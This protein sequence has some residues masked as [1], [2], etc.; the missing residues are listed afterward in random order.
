M[1]SSLRDD[2]STLAPR[3]PEHEVKYPFLTLL[4]SGKHT[5][6]VHTKSA[7]NHRI[8]VTVES[9]I[10]LGDVL[11]KFAREL[12]PKSAIPPGAKTV[13]YP[14]LMEEFVGP[15]PRLAYTACATRRREHEVYRSEH[16]WEIPSP[17]R[18]N[19]TRAYN[20]S[21]LN[22]SLHKIL[23]ARSGDA[24]FTDELRRALAFD[25]MRIAFEHVMSRVVM[26][27]EEDDE[28][29]AAP[30]GHLVLSGGV[31]SNLLLRTVARRTL[32][33]RGFPGVRVATPDPKWCTDNAAMIAF[34]G[35]QMFL[36]GW[37]TDAAFAPLS[38]W[39]IEEL[40]TGVDTWRRRPGVVMPKDMERDAATVRRLREAGG[41][42]APASASASASAS[43]DG[44]DPAVPQNGRVP[45]TADSEAQ[46][47]NR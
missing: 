35:A 16:G 28:L 46:R 47:G 39:S 12:V 3:A 21:G 33:A 10:A 2:S 34:A 36:G 17:L 18:E 29:R 4:V 13:V 15:G 11:D 6:L 30:P 22:G 23:R 40:L 27:L 43:S 24:D 42:E 5:M 1:E 26:V 19:R 45:E 41:G 44:L 25:V 8:L 14:R 32:D 38:A 20:F 31:A 7:V 9:R 37:E